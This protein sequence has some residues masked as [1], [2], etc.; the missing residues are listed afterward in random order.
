VHRKH[1]RIP[2]PQRHHLGARLHARAPLGH[3]EL[4][5][6]E[7]APRLGQQD[8]ELQWKNMLAVP[9]LVQAVLRK[10]RVE[11]LAKVADEIGQRVAEVLVFAAPEAVRIAHTP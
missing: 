9:V 1:D 3:H 11:R 5:A 2:L 8:G 4:P 7:I 10:R 6:G